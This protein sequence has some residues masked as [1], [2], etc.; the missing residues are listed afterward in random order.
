[1]EFNSNETGVSYSHAMARVKRKYES[2]VRTE[3]AQ[4]TR[5]AIAKAARR[6]FAAR[7]FAGTPIESIAQEAGV[8]VQTVYAVFRTKRAVLLSMLDAVDDQADVGA[9]RAQL[10]GGSVAAQRKAV[11]RFMTR[12]FTRGGDIIVATRAAGAAD[13]E[14]RALLKKGLERHRR[15]SRAIIASWSKAGALRRGLSAAD[16]AD[17]LDA[18]TSFAIYAELRSAGWSARKYEQWLNDAIERL[19]LTTSASSE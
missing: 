2:A 4:R 11:A 6:L 3:S 7:G 19:V 13:P 18:I 15:G 12:L 10:A 1:M 16:A 9:L 5:E 14:L 17:A 8:S